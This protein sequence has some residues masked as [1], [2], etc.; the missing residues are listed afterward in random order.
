MVAFPLNGEMAKCWKR[1]RIESAGGMPS[2]CPCRQPMS[3]M[4]LETSSDHPHNDS[5]TRGMKAT[6]TSRHAATGVYDHLSFHPNRKGMHLS[7]GSPP[8]RVRYRRVE[9]TVTFRAAGSPLFQFGRKT[10]TGQLLEPGI[11]DCAVLLKAL[12]QYQRRYDNITCTNAY[13]I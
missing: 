9:I 6:P 1:W 5:T 7:S 8:I 4:V 10:Y 12:G 2:L 13:I 3:E 11:R